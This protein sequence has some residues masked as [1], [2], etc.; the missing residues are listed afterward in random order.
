VIPTAAIHHVDGEAGVWQV[1]DDEL[2]YTPISMGIADLEGYV[3]IKQGLKPG[4][5][6][7]VYS[8]NPIHAQG[9]FKVVEHIPGVPQ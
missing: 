7:V 1:V 2:H 8:E 5:Q 9:N 6:I 3:Q 4:D